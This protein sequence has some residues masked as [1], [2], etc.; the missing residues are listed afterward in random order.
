MSIKY[1]FFKN[2]GKVDDALKVWK[3]VS[4]YIFERENLLKIVESFEKIASDPEYF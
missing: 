4:R 1:G 3:E 2:S